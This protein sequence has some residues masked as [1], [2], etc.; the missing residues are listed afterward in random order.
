MKT[1]VSENRQPFAINF[2]KLTNMLSP[3]CQSHGCGQT[4]HASWH[5]NAIITGM[6]S[7]FW[8]VAA[9][10][11]REHDGHVIMSLSLCSAWLAH[12]RPD[13]SSWWWW[14]VTL[15]LPAA[16]YQE[17]LKTGSDLGLALP[18]APLAQCWSQCKRYSEEEDQALGLGWRPESVS[19]LS[20]THF[21]NQNH[22]LIVM[23]LDAERQHF[24]V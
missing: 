12:A 16:C 20:N 7:C 15:W 6:F 24:H 1:C 14:R 21:Q 19:Y 4:Q 18:R 23:F 13:Y 3:H 5:W 2:A 8:D 22:I 11:R 9:A 10:K 17:P